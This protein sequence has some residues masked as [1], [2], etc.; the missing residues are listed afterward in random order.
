MK[1]KCSRQKECQEQNAREC[2]GVNAGR[3]VNK[4]QDQL[5]LDLRQHSVI[6]LTLYYAL[7]TILK[8]ENL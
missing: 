3:K 2:K 7:G 4:G 6:K 5:L 1:K 8:A